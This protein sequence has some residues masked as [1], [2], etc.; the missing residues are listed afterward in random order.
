MDTS[1][2]WAGAMKLIFML[3]PFLAGFLAITYANEII[4]LITSV[5][6]SRR[7]DWD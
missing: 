2:L 1:E 3:S 5:F 4:G 6:L 7:K